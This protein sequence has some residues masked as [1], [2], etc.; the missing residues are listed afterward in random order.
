MTLIKLG[1]CVYCGKPNREFSNYCS[2]RCEKLML[3]KQDEAREK[4]ICIWCFE[5]K[6]IGGELQ[7]D[8]CEICYDE[9]KKMV[10]DFDKKYKLGEYKK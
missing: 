2:D 9:L 7:N 6:S 5:N 8:A 10:N 3:N 1:A 4:N